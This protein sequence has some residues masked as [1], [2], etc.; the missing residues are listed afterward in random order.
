MGGHKNGAY[1]KGGLYIWGEKL[2]RGG[3]IKRGLV[4]GV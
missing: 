4:G 2:I 3:V 1:L